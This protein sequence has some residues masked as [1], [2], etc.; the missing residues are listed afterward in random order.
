[1]NQMGVGVSFSAQDMWSQPI[2]AMVSSYGRIDGAVGRSEQQF[3]QSMVSVRSGLDLFRIGLGGLAALEPASAAASAFGQSVAEISTLT[4]EASLNSGYLGAEL[5]KLNA[6]YGGGTATQAKALYDGI[7][8]GAANAAEA[9]SLLEASNRAAVAGKTEVSVALDGLT[10]ALNAYGV[11]FTN[12][13]AYSDTFFTAV[14]KGKTTLPELAGVIGRVAPTAA[15][16]QIS[17]EDLNAALAAVTLKGLKTE[18]AATG[19]KA[20]FANIIK[21]TKEAGDEAKKLGIDFSAAALR[22]KGFPTFL[23]D[24]T[25]SADFNQD[26]LS[27]LFGSVEALNS[28]LALTANGGAA[29]NGALDAMKGKGGAVDGAFAKMADTMAFQEKRM[30]GLK[31]N[32]LVF[33]GQGIEPLRIGVLKVANAVLTAFTQIPAPIRDVAVRIFA[34]VSS[35]LGAIGAVVGAKAAIASFLAAVGVTASELM[36]TLAPVVLAIGA[37]ALAFFALREAY[38]RNLGGLG[39]LIDGWVDGAV[40][41]WQALSQIFSDGG[42]SGAV[43]DDLARAENMGIKNFVVGVF[44]AVNRIKNFFSS[45]ADGF[46]DAV[47]EMQPI[48]TAF[49]SSLDT[50]ADA[51]SGL[52]ETNDPADA[53]SAFEKFG[54]VGR[55]VGGVLAGVAGFVVKIVTAGV[56]LVSGFIS[57]FG[58]IKTAAQPIINLFGD[59]VTAIVDAASVFG[60]AGGNFEGVGQG[61]ASIIAFVVGV[62][63][64]LAPAFKALIATAGVQLKGLF[65][66]VSGVIDLVAGILSGDWSRAWAGAKKIVLGVINNIVAGLLGFVSVAAA[67]VDKVLGFFGVDS[68]LASTIQDWQASVSASLLGGDKPAATA[69]TGVA[70]A[71]SSANAMSSTPDIAPPPLTSS[72]GPLQAYVDGGPITS[73]VAAGMKGAPAP[74]TNVKVTLDGADLMSKI[75]SEGRSTDAASFTPG[76]PVVG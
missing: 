33:I 9:T 48:F 49:T 67:I 55:T 29:F 71:A 10:S 62:I 57:N 56:Q 2:D 66:V 36:M 17:F 34:F 40:L 44:L 16:L 46:F 76:I 59:I 73:A 39:D 3:N 54:E 14:Q 31:E 11:S 26:S 37:V 50:L 32:A 15:A 53:T 65:T 47:N 7:S 42:F 12:A 52:W 68:A 6:A 63:A 43:R 64:T 25:S 41:A 22:A 60:S 51:F 35:F 70:T 24:I 4:S 74:V 45:I 30:E 8:A 58:K 72:F 38:D 69:T 13:A 19:L 18:E 23:K 61:I 1:M 20:A 27:K 75:E 5:L 28:V 21:P